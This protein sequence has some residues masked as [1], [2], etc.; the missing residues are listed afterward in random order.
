MVPFAKPNGKIY[1]CTNFHNLNKSY[2]KINFPLPNI[3]QLADSIR[4]HEMLSLMDG[5]LGYNMLEIIM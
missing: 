1:V 2:P 4:G 3:D 5:F